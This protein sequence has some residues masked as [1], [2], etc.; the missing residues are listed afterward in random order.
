PKEN[1]ML[2]S[3]RNFVQEKNE[4]WFRKYRA[5]S[6]NDVWGTRGSLGQNFESL[7]KELEMLEVLTENRDKVIWARAQGKDLEVDD[8]NVPDPLIVGTHITRHVE[9]IDGVKAIGRMTFPA[10]LEVNL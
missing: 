6:G 10:D 3:V 2:S 8:N 1:E 5:T 4:L 7:Q 9:Y